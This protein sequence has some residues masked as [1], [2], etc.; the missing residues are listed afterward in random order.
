M[1]A[2]V[3]FVKA[4]MHNKAMAK[5]DEEYPGAYPRARP[6]VMVEVAKGKRDA[7][8]G[9]YKGPIDPE[10]YY[11]APDGDMYSELNEKQWAVWQKGMFGVR[12]VWTVCTNCNIETRGT[13]WRLLT[14]D[15]SKF[16]ISKGYAR[17]KCRN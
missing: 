15:L 4:V 12:R 13:A 17:P 11:F 16:G 10:L 3:N 14:R 5:F 7:N 8:T 6:A 9:V 2:V 1:T